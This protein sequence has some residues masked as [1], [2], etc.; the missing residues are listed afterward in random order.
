VSSATGFHEGHSWAYPNRAQMGSTLGPHGLPMKAPSELPMR[1]P[2]VKCN[3]FHHGPSYVS[4]VMYLACLCRSICMPVCLSVYLS[5]CVCIHTHTR[6]RT[7]LRTLVCI[8]VFIF[9]FVCL[10]VCLS[11][12]MSVCMSVSRYICMHARTR[13]RANTGMYIC[14]SC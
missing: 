4:Y 10:T 5:K 1:V 11:A 6:A 14:K 3:I 12:C 2:R 7:C 9:L 8:S 13:M